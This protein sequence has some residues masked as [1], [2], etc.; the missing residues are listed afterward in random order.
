MLIHDAGIE[1]TTPHV[2]TIVSRPRFE[3]VRVVNCYEREERGE[4]SNSM[5]KRANAALREQ[6]NAFALRD[7][8]SVR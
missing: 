5:R 7:V 8:H 1:V 4:E 6:H 2:E 3:L